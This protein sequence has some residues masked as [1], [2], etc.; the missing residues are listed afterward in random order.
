MEKEDSAHKF[1]KLIEFFDGK[2]L[3]MDALIAIC[4]DGEPANT[5]I[6]TGILRRFELH[7][8]RPLHWFICLLH[9]NELPFRHLFENSEKSSTA[10]PRAT[11]GNLSKKIAEAIEKLQVCK[12]IV[13]YITIFIK[14]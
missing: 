1:I 2:Q 3:S 11:T 6:H 13:I 7:L 14:W 10:R 5:G 4:S 8:K 12:L 9:F